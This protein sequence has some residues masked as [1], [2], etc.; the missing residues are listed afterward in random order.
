MAWG[1]GRTAVL[2]IPVDY[3]G[4]FCA[5]LLR[6]RIIAGVSGDDVIVFCRRV[7]LSF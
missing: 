4:I 7:P 3:S 5:R 6:H 1:V 2:K